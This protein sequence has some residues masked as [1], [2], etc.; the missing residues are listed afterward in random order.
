[1]KWMATAT[2]N[3]PTARCP[4]SRPHEDGSRSEPRTQVTFVVPASTAARRAMD[5]MSGSGSTPRTAPTRAA[6]GMLIWP[7][8]QPR[9]TTVSSAPRRNAE[10][11]A[12][13]TAG[14]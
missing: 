10:V 9:S 6:S 7:V 2:V 12:S 11:S 13:S 8:P 4:S 1:M 5:S 14:G 3:A